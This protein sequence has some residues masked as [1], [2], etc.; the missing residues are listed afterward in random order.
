VPNR[1]TI[2][3]SHP[4]AGDTGRLIHSGDGALNGLAGFPSQMVH[5]E[6]ALEVSLQIQT[7][8]IAE[9]SHTVP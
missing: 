9:Q 1:D 3:P 7:K 5:R 6:K 8:Q 4:Q 2:S